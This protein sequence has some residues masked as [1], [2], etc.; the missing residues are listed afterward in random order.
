M[1]RDVVDQCIFCMIA[2]GEMSARKVY[3]DDHRY[4]FR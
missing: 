4:R 2:K 1:R 3:E